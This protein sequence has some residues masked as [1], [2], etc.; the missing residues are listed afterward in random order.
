MIL[1]L[2]KILGFAVAVSCVMTWAVFRFTPDPP[3]P[4]APAPPPEVRDV[5]LMFAPVEHE[6]HE[7]QA[8]QERAAKRLAD[9]KAAA[10][11]LK[12]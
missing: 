7:A 8:A 11:K 5:L 3:P 4:V 1:E 6:L 10:S 12:Q 9:A 2:A